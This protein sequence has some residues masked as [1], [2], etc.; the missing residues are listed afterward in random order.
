MQDV[1]DVVHIAGV[2]VRVAPGAREVSDRLAQQAGV[3]THIDDTAT[4]QL[5]VTID[6]P[7]LEAVRAIHEAIGRVPGVL[8]AHLVC[9]IADPGATEPARAGGAS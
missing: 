9:H 1:A 5:V 2:L 6:A 4:G 7:T 3:E 8:S